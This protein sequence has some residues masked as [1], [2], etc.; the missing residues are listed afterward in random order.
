MN[1]EIIAFAL[2]A[3]WGARGLRSS[4]RFSPGLPGA[5]ARSRSSRSRW[6]SANAPIPN[7]DRARNSR[8]ERGG[9]VHIQ[10]LV[11]IQELLT[12]ARQR[13]QLGVGLAGRAEVARPPGEEAARQVHFFRRGGPLVGDLPGVGGLPRRRR[14]R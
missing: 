3:K 9:S 6:A 4:G 14:G 11:G 1:S 12:K 10:E 2:G 13:G 7:A 5:S 8:R